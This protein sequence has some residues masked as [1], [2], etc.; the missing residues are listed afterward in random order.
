MNKQVK[1]SYT[2]EFRESAVNLVIGSDKSTASIAKDLGIK[3]TTLYSWVNKAKDAD[4]KKDGTSNAQMFDPKKRSS[5]CND[6]ISSTKLLIIEL[7][8]SRLE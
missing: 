1:R 8:F 4:S 6:I 7:F 3:T 2:A 5:P